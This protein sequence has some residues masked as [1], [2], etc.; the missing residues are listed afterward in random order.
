MKIAEITPENALLLW[1]DEPLES[2]EIDNILSENDYCYRCIDEDDF[3]D[4]IVKRINE[5]R[6]INANIH[7]DIGYA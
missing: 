5:L 3:S 6:K 7:W 1:E 4:T 2:Y